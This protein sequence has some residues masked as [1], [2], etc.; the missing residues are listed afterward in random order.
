MGW[1]EFHDLVGYIMHNLLSDE[2]DEDF[3][4]DE[5]PQLWCF[6]IVGILVVCFKHEGCG[7]IKLVP[8]VASLESFH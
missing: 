7:L 6:N 5:G 3:T 8:N 2:L 1:L 4:K